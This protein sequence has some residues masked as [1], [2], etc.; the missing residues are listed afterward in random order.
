[1]FLGCH[2]SKLAPEETLIP[3]GVS[4][5]FVGVL[6][7]WFCINAKVARLWEVAKGHF[8]LGVRKSWIKFHDDLPAFLH[9]W[10]TEHFRSLF[11]GD[12]SEKVVESLLQ[13]P[14]HRYLSPDPVH[15][16]HTTHGLVDSFIV[17][18]SYW[19]QLSVSRGISWCYSLL[20]LHTVVYSPGR[21][22]GT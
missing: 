5:V 4:V 15:S 21:K 22:S 16:Q 7:F 12:S 8:K 14:L 10:N 19:H 20:P 17:C 2:D 18:F 13:I 6:L 11:K 1:M 9:G 3:F